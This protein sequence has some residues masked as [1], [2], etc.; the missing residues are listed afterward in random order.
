M[1]LRAVALA[2]LIVL[3][4]GCG[5]GSGSGVTQLAG[6]WT[7]AVSTSAPGFS[8]SVYHVNLVS[9]PCT[10][11]T[12]VGAFGEDDTY[13]FMADNA[14][15]GSISETGSYFYAPQAVLVESYSN[16]LANGPIA[17]GITFIEANPN[18][19]GAV[20]VFGGRGTLSS[21][22]ETGTWIC[23]A[24]PSCMVTTPQGGEGILSGTFT[25]NNN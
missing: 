19:Y 9:G 25:G 22:G 5:S 20:A 16:T 21:G 17:F 10:I 13:C 14:G 2:A 1:K 23:A 8:G 4:I 24:A 7:I 15:H 11:Q 3:A 12:P 18:Q 6:N